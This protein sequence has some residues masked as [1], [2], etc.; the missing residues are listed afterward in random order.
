MTTAFWMGRRV[1]VTGHT[2][3]KGG[4]LCI[5]LQ[6][7]GADVAG[8]ALAP[9]TRPNLFEAA[10]IHQGMKSNVGDV[11]DVAQLTAQI[12]EHKP[13]VIFHLAAQPLVR[14]S[15]EAPLETYATNVLGTANVLD[16]VRATEGV[17][18]VVV[19]TSDKCYDLRPRRERYREDDALGGHDPYSTSKAAAEFVVAGYRASF[20]GDKSVAAPAV[21]TAR[22]GNVIGGGDWSTDRLVPDLIAAFSRGHAAHVREP[23]AIRPWQHVLDPIRGYVCLAQRL[24]EDDGARFAEAWNFGPPASNE[25]RVADVADEAAKIWGAKAGWQRDTSEHPHEAKSLRLDS[26]KA[27]GRLGWQA[28]ISLRG[29]LEHTITWHRQFAAGA[30]ARTLMIA[31]IDALAMHAVRS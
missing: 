16:A 26:S 18:A 23:D 31:D 6:R 22:S 15:Y 9:L 27:A 1:F 24:C 30:D 7:L 5:W 4:W 21:A 17:R 29:A 12:H 8:Y 25:Q 13:E 11:G 3:F 19:V 10:N 14:R 20:W 2:G 28:Q